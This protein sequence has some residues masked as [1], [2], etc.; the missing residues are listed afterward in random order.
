[1][2]NINFSN[3]LDDINIQLNRWGGDASTF[4]GVIIA[5]LFINLLSLALPIT[6]T[7][8][9]DRIIPNLALN[10][11]FLLTVGV[12]VALIIEMILRFTR[13]VINQWADARLEHTLS[14]EMYGKL[15][16]VDLTKHD[17]HTPN[18]FFETMQSIA[19]YKNY[20]G[21]HL[22]I[23]YIDLSFVVVFLFI[24]YYIAGFLFLVPLVV[25]GF[26]TFCLRKENIA[27]HEPLVKKYQS[28]DK[29]MRFLSNIFENIHTLKSMAMEKLIARRYERLL[30]NTLEV[31]YDLNIK[32]SKTQIYIAL[33]THISIVL[34]VIFGAMM[35]VNNT[36]TIG[37]LAAC[38]ILV[39]RIIQPISRLDLLWNKNVSLNILAGGIGKIKSLTT[40]H[41]DVAI[42]P[43][44]SDLS[45]K[46]LTLKSKVGNHVIINNLHF[47]IKQGEL[48]G[49]QDANDSGVITALF[50][51]FLQMYPIAEGQLFLDGQDI[52][53]YDSSDLSQF[54]SYIP[55]QAAIFKGSVIENMAMFEPSKYDDVI[56]I[57]K[58]IGLHSVM[59]RL[60]AGY[61]TVLGESVT[62]ILSRGIEQRIAIVRYLSRGAKV[63]L[64]DNADN[65]LD[66]DARRQLVEYLKTLKDKVTVLIH[67]D[68]SDM[69]SIVNRTIEL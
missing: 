4:F 16:N 14:V 57:S 27:L 41:D 60:P 61:D 39:G 51:S 48:V 13:E 18:N 1:M 12:F 49:L 69:I 50:L 64:F 11:L 9:Y 3:L 34:V 6:L 63:I 67:S 52:R 56:D 22:V 59:T 21:S 40:Q 66:S 25:V 37:S 44:G 62:N 45:C 29:R 10:T 31:E 30:K 47:D 28:N 43:T 15:L 23:V 65:S 55:S 38:I 46:N 42:E 54:I 36:L 35:I 5:T 17:K 19:A 2:K 68:C 8:I 24:I 58:K 32:N 53:R 20:F 26:F 33:A 7:Q